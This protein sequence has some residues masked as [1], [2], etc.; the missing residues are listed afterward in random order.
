MGTI[1]KYIGGVAVLLWMVGML[2]LGH[3][4]VVLGPQPIKCER[5]VGR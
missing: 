1:L 5:G 2:G 3:F 4:A